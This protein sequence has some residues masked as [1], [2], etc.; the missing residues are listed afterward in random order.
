MAFKSSKF[1]SSPVT[2]LTGVAAAARSH[3]EAKGYTVEILESSYGYFISL[4]KG[5]I[6]KSVLGL[7]TSLNIDVKKV[8]GGVSVDAKVG[9]FG[10]QLIPSL[11]M[12]FVAW[13]VI[14]TQI[15][16]LVQQ[17]KLDNEAIDVIEEA[18]RNIE[19]GKSF[20]TGGEKQFCTECGAEIAATALF[21]SA[22]GTKQK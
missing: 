1:I 20:N 12:W 19:N 8:S 18:I 15:T 21:C 3:F 2:D 9:I 17:A 5:G 13:P 16:G 4:T 14:L 11:I 22:C 10:Q 7:K 6:F